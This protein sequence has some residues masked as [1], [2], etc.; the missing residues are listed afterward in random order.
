MYLPSQK[1]PKIS[2]LIQYVKL[3]TKF[4]LSN[5][6]INDRYQRK[7]KQK[8]YYTKNNAIEKIKK[9]NYF[10]SSKKHY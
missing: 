2:N 1:N 10:I 6:T 3:Y 4:N 9:P 7:V 5:K 8:S